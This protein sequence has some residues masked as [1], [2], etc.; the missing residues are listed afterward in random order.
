MNTENKQIV[1]RWFEEVWN[2]QNEAVIDELL[3]P[4]IVVHGLGEEAAQ[5]HAAFRR[6]FDGFRKNFASY[7][8]DIERTVAE[9]DLVAVHCKVTAKRPGDERTLVFRGVSLNRV[10]D[11]KLVEGWNHFDYLELLQQLGAVGPDAMS[12][13][14]G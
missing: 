5:G 2:Q 4:A 11:G 12:A 3:D 13:V 1:H 8:I 14:M 10:A 7:R 9:G 6:F